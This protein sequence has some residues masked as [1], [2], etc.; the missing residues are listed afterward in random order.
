[1]KDPKVAAVF[2]WIYMV[3]NVSIF[4]QVNKYY[5]LQSMEIVYLE[6]LPSSVLKMWSAAPMD[7]DK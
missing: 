1:M 6:I 4:R 3:N 5:Q 7:V 2:F